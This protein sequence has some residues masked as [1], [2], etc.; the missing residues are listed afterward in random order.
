MFTQ[1][2]HNWNKL[3]KNYHEPFKFIQ[4]TFILAGHYI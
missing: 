3:R 1:K 2:P 4:L